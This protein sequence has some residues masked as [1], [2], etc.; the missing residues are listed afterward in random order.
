[1]HQISSSARINIEQILQ[2][3]FFKLKQDVRE[4]RFQPG[5]GNGTQKEDPENTAVDIDPKEHPH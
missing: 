4:K 2:S 5:G 3:F 1:M